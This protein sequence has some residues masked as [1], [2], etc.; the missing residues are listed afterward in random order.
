MTCTSKIFQAIDSSCNLPTPGIEVV[1]YIYNRTD[2]TPTI[3]GTN[4]VKI[5]D[6]DIAATK[7]GFKITGYKKNMNAGHDLVKAED[8]P[9]RY[10]HYFSFH[11]YEF[12]ADAVKNVDSLEDLVVVVERKE[13]PTDADGI[14]IIYGLHAGLT[15]STD[16]LRMNDANSVRKI[17]LVTTDG[18][19]E[20]HSQY[21]LIIADNVSPYAATKALLEAT[22]TAVPA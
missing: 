1:A 15:T 2:I 6:L 20:I 14:F 13:K 19:T 16:T 12:D 21:N 17:E 11:G 8:A 9:N 22:L 10:T 7:T 5:T 3:N 18:G 4:S